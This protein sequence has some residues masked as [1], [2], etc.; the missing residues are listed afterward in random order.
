MPNNL[1]SNGVLGSMSEDFGRAAEMIKNCLAARSPMLLRHHGD[2]DGICAALSVYLSAKSM[3][4]ANF[5]GYRKKMLIFS[6]HPAI[7]SL[8]S[9]LDDMELIRNMQP[10]SSPLAVLLD[11]SVNLESIDSLNA[12]RKSN[13]NIL[14]VDHHPLVPGIKEAATL[15]VTP[16]LHGGSSDYSAGFIAGEVAKR[17][18]HFYGLEELQEIALIGDKSKLLTY[19]EPELERKALVLDFMSSS[20]EFAE[21]LEVYESVLKNPQNVSSIYNRAMKKLESVKKDAMRYSKLKELSNGFKLVLVKLDKVRIG[22]FPAK[23]RICGEVHEEY[24]KKLDAPL[25]TIAYEEGAMHFRANGKARSAG[26]NANKLIGELKS[27]MTDAIE[28]GGGHDV[29]AGLRIRKGFDR[30]VLE[31]I[32]K[33]IGDIAK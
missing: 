13:F 9:V 17:I 12:L 15:L 6:N 25:V 30:M 20:S 32:T 5:E 4:G 3:L 29:A 10:A 22:E 21:S 27:E 11:F 31:E 8:R 26:F 19:H 33:K 16:W 1:P 14:I 7:Y 18:N 23:G 2:C 24:D 28:S